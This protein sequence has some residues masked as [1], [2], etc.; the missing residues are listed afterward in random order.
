MLLRLGDR[1]LSGLDFLVL[2]PGRDLVEAGLIGLE[3]FTRGSDLRLGGLALRVE[4]SVLGCGES[5]LGD[6]LMTAGSGA[7]KV[8]PFMRV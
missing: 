4:C 7:G 1:V 5:G 3:F 2:R 6:R 8:L